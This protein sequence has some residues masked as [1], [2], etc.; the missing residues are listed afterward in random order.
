M[1]TSPKVANSFRKGPDSFSRLGLGTG[2]LASLGRAASLE[3]VTLLLEAMADCGVNVIDTA[4]SYGS[5]DCEIILGK[6]LRKHGGSFHLITKAGYRLSNFP[7]PL[8]PLNQFAKKAIQRWGAMQCFDA[9]YLQHSLEQS[10]RRLKR[11]QVDA[12]LLHDPK[13]DIVTNDEIL[14]TCESLQTCGKAAMVGVSS[15]DYEVIQTAVK[16]GVFSIIQTPANIAVA[17]SLRVVWDEAASR[18]LHL[19][20]NH[21]YS[22]ECLQLP[23]MNHETL[24]RACAGYFPEHSTILCGTRNPSHLQQTE[25][26]AREA[27]SVA[28]SWDIV[29]QFTGR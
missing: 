20:G 12:F 2:T 1:N 11:D 6:A 9:D 15:G 13:I 17:N 7:G 3:T 26:W 25:S 22:P 24:M 18:G 5:G 21:I 4:D 27:M 19:I 14:R 28:D 23:A 10:L 29:S 16:T 8:R